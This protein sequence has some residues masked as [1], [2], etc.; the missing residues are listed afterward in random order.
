M[1]TYKYEVIKPKTHI[2]GTTLVYALGRAEPEREPQDMA[3]RMFG[4][5]VRFMKESIIDGNP[6]TKVVIF[7]ANKYYRDNLDA[8]LDALSRYDFKGL[9]IFKADVTRYECDIP[10]VPVRPKDACMCWNCHKIGYKHSLPADTKGAY[11][12][13]TGIFLYTCKPC[14]DRA[15]ARAMANDRT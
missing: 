13:D 11:G 8:V 14:A 3:K 9:K 10:A 1:K 5:I 4:V 7:G 12:R 15:F 6:L 2:E